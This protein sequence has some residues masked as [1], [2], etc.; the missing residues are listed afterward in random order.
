MIPVKLIQVVYVCLHLIE[1]FYLKNVDTKNKIDENNKINLTC[2]GVNNKFYMAEKYTF[3]IKRLLLPY[4]SSFWFVFF[5]KQSY[6]AWA[7][8]PRGLRLPM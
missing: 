3:A 5:V 6:V 8:S 1:T 2:L 7:A 4:K